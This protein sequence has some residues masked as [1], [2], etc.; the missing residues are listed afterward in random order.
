MI[1]VSPDHA[2]WYDDELLEKIKKRRFGGVIKAEIEEGLGNQIGRMM[3]R[4]E[5]EAATYILSKVE[6]WERERGED[7]DET[8][9]EADFGMQRV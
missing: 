9:D 1:Y 2:C 6:E 7:A 4:Y 8:E 3:K 5:E